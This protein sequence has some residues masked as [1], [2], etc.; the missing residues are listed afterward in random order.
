[1]R[2]T[3]S[4]GTGAPATPIRLLLRIPVPWVFAL[5]YLA[6]FGLERAFPP[7]LLLPVIAPLSLPAGVFLF[8]VGLCSAAWCLATFRKGQTTTTPGQ[9]SVRLVKRGLYRVSRNPMYVSLLLMYVGEALIL[10]QAW[11]IILLPLVVI[12]IDRIVIPLEEARLRER[13]REEYEQYRSN[14]RRWM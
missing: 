11:P 10:R 14:V 2:E 12:Y 6:G 8:I 5:A 1:M 7:G 3:A 4:R 13:F 9:T